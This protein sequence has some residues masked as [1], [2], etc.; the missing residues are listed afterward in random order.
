[1][2]KALERVGDGSEGFGEVGD[3]ASGVGEGRWW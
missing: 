1:M 3:G 2:V